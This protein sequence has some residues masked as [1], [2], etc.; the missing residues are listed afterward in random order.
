MGSL[1]YLVLRQFT[2]PGH[3]LNFSVSGFPLQLLP[4]PDLSDTHVG[5][6]LVP[7]AKKL[8]A[9]GHVAHYFGARSSQLADW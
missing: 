7:G 3:A 1:T 5:V 2:P 8:F 6:L 9:G 4:R